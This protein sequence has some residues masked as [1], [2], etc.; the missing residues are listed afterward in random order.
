MIELQLLEQLVAF[1]QHGTLSA[2]SAALHLSQPSL[3]RSM[4]KLE[5]LLG[6]PLFEREKNRIRLNPT[7]EVAAA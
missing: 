3:T 6:V 1:E 7:G 5:S 2:A 4:Q